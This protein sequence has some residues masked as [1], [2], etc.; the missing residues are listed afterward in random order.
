MRVDPGIDDRFHH[1][2]MLEIIVSLEQGIP[3][4][5]LDQDTPDAPYIAGVGPTK[6]QDDLWRPVMPRRH[7]RRVVFILEGGRSEVDK[8]DLRVKKHSPLSSLPTDRSRRRRDLAII[9][10]GLVLVMA[11][12]NVLG[13]QVGMDQ[14]EIMED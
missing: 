9:R 12:K 1:G 6:A 8:P 13:L 10:E 11:Q 14:V 2:Q 5:E 4:K 3:G 7:D